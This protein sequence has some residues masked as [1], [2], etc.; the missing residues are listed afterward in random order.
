MNR[1]FDIRQILFH[2]S[3]H[4][5]G[6][7]LAENLNLRRKN[8]SNRLIFDRFGSILAIFSPRRVRSMPGNLLDL[9]CLNIESCTQHVVGN[10]I[11]F[12]AQKYFEKW[13][14]RMV[15][16]FRVFRASWCIRS[17]TYRNFHPRGVKFWHQTKCVSFF[18]ES[19]GDFSRVG[20]WIFLLGPVFTILPG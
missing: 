17:G 3:Y 2:H 5:W 16:L 8:V 7:V 1:W 15:P 9:S 11:Q 4:V 18:S 12:K 20:F 13:R 19:R 14:R 6:G 10:Q